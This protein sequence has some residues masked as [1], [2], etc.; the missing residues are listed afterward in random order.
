MNSYRVYSLDNA[1]HIGWGHEVVCGT[2]EDALMKAKFGLRACEKAEVWTGDR[3]V[4]RVAGA[5]RS[6]AW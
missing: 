3:C 6:D 2:D 1:G 4:G 5:Q